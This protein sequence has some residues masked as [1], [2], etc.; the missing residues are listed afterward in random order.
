MDKSRG[1][2]RESRMRVLA[3]WMPVKKLAREAGLKYGTVITWFNG[4]SRMPAHGA[5]TIAKYLH[6]PVE[7]VTI[8]HEEDY[9]AARDASR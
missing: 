8:A 6:V 4:R 1:T 3:G 2:E 9:R 5:L 7:D